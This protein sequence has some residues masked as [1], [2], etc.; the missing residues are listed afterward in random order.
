MEQD[1]KAAALGFGGNF[2]GMLVIRQNGDGQGVR[3]SKDCICRSAIV[4]QIVE[5]NRKPRTRRLARGAIGSRGIPWTGVNVNRVRSYARFQ[6]KEENSFAAFGRLFCQTFA[7]GHRSERLLDFR[8]LRASRGVR[9]IWK[10]RDIQ[11]VG[12]LGASVGRLKRDANFGV[13]RG[14]PFGRRREFPGDGVDSRWRQAR[15]LRLFTATGDQNQSNKE[16]EQARTVETSP[17][18]Q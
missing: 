12:G 17:G 18:V 8:D 15:R 3:K 10:N 5:N 6:I 11:M 9:G 2:D 4:P 13:N 16:K 1:L 14:C 7:S